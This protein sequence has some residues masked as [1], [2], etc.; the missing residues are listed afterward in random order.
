VAVLALLVPSLGVAAAGV[1]VL[2]GFDL[3]ALHVRPHFGDGL[4]MAIVIMAA[5]T[6]GAALGDLLWWVT[7]RNRC[8][9]DDGEPRPG[10]PLRRARPSQSERFFTPGRAKK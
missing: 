3:H 2:C 10:Q 6:A 7:T 5:V 4:V 9:A 8:A 1:Y